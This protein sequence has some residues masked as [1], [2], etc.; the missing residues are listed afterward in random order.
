MTTNP[1]AH[2]DTW[3]F[4]MDDTLYHPDTG[5]LEGV[6]HRVF[7]VVGDMLKL[8]RDDTKALLNTYREKHGF[9]FPGLKQNP[10]FDMAEFIHRVYDFDD[11]DKITP[12]ELT[13]VNV[14]ALKGTK[15]LWTNSPEVWMNRVLAALGKKH[16]FDH[17]F[18][19]EM[20]G[21]MGKP[22]LTSYQKVQADL[23][24]NPAHIVLIDD[25]PD[26]LK[27]AK[28]LGWT[29]VL[30]HGRKLPEH[31]FVDYAY[32]DLLEFLKVATS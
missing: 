6:K 17:F 20:F 8:S 4:D 12:C 14:A 18:H 16:L 23:G 9:S 29:T 24:A 15:V 31:D 11:S 27:P 13:K 28:A 5:I 22:Y 19:N 1:F 32:D 3:I 7:D 21:F 30:V 2:I 26:N 10:D 25:T